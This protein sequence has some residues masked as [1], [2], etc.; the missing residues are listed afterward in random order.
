[1]LG[2]WDAAEEEL[3][4]AVDSDGLADIEYLTCE[5]GWLAALAW[6][7]QDRR[8]P[9]WRDCGTCAPAKTPQDKSTISVAEAFTAAARGQPAGRAASRA[10]G[11]R[12]R[13]RPGDQPSS[14]CAGHGRWPRAPRSSCGDTAALGELLAA[15]R[16]LP[17]RPRRPAAAGRAR[18]GPR[19]PGRPARRP[20]R[21]G[22]LR[23]RDRQPARAEHS[24][25]SGPRPA[26]PRPVPAGHGDADAAALAIEE[27]R[28]I[29]A[30]CAASRCLTAPTPHRQLG[31]RRRPPAA[32]RQRRDARP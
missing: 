16:R 12:A 26:R 7:R 13:R 11:A 10:C 30:G 3:T 6:R 22:R 9:C 21:R 32:S 19:P 1:M 27:A 18:P 17:A 23:R 29:G 24:L 25:P 4:Q 31:T 14:T 20:G 5:R 15:A 8:R 28:D 2:D